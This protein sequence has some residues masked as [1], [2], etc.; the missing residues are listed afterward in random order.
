M[1]WPDFLARC[2]IETASSRHGETAAGCG[3]IAAFG[4]YTT[5][6]YRSRSDVGQ[7]DRNIERDSPSF[8]NL[9]LGEMPQRVPLTRGSHFIWSGGKGMTIDSEL[10]SRHEGV[11]MHV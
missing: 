7:R 8:W 10:R 5:E 6:E 11:V 3:S 9:F 2:L 1:G 4:S